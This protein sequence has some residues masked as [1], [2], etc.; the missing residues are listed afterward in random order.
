MPGG[1]LMVAMDGQHQCQPHIAVTDLTGSYL[2]TFRTLC[3]RS[4]CIGIG[5]YRSPS[6]P[7]PFRLPLLKFRVRQCPTWTCCSLTASWLQKIRTWPCGQKTERSTPSC[8]ASRAPR[9]ATA[10]AAN[11]TCIS[12]FGSPAPQAPWTAI[13][14]DFALGDLVRV[15]V[16]DQVHGG[17]GDARRAWPEA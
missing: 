7:A 3:V 2:H 14:T 12:M 5:E 10:V 17:P 11:H 9:A 16:P 15:R 13:S 1:I 8:P 4:S 6:F